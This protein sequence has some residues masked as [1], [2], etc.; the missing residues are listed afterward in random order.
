MFGPFRHVVRIAAAAFLVSATPA[1]AGTIY[2]LNAT[3]LFPASFTSFSIRFNDTS[4]DGLLQLGEISSFSGVTINSLTYPTVSCV[5]NTTLSTGICAQN[6]WGFVRSGGAAGATTNTWT[7]ALTPVSAVPL[8][9]ALLLLTSAL[10]LMGL[11][12]WWIT[13][14]TPALLLAA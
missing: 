6:E 3:T 2:D 9:P 1:S 10:G 4:G 5:P 8:P 12:R 13:R 14:R 11:A 7:Y